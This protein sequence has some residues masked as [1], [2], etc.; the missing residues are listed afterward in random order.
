MALHD[1][2]GDQTEKE[3]I[4]ESIQVMRLH[5]SHVRKPNTCNGTVSVLPSWQTNLRNR[6]QVGVKIQGMVAKAAAH[7]EDEVSIVG[8]VE[9]L[10]LK[11]RSDKFFPVIAL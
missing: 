4:E 9:S 1:D 11:K 8:T 10:T 7:G 2:V 6:L 5:Y 3:N